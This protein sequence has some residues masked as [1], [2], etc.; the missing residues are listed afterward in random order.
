V[1]AL[2]H[3]RTACRRAWWRRQGEQHLV[4]TWWPTDYPIGV[5]LWH[6]GQQY[7][8]TQYDRT[9]D[10]RLFSVW[11]KP[12]V[13]GAASVQPDPRIKRLIRSSTRAY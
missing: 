6:H 5:A 2:E 1:E 9:P 3:I 13:R 10:A 11:A 7:L 12:V 8:I 4:D